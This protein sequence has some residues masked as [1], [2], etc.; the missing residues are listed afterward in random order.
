ME[1]SG[2]VSAIVSRVG[3]KRASTFNVFSHITIFG[4]NTI[5]V[6]G[7]NHFNRTIIPELVYNKL[8]GLTTLTHN[9]DRI[10]R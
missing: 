1:A 8:D 3:R 9:L 2:L 5:V 4:V 10:L 6:V 7:G